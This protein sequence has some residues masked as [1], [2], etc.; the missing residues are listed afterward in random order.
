MTAVN[1]AFS[2]VPTLRERLWRSLGFRYHLGNEP[3]DADL[4]PGW[5]LTDIV[6][7]FGWA[8]RLRLLTTGRLSISSIVHFDTPS[9]DV[10]KSRVDWRIIAPG[11]KTK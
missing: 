7:N 6:L 2:R 4:L 11:E 8:D 9:P 10:C 3:P 5:M 1:E